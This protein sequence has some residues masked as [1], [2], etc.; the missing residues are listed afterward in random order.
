M[1]AFRMTKDGSL[2]RSYLRICAVY[3]CLYRYGHTK[4]FAIG[5]LNDVMSTGKAEALYSIWLSGPLRHRAPTL[6]PT[7]PH[8]TPTM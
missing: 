2:D 1:N 3:R 6:P 5:N 4:E 8:A 7:T